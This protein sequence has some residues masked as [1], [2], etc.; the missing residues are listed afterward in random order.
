MQQLLKIISSVLALTVSVCAHGQT[1]PPDFNQQMQKILMTHYNQYKDQEYFSGA[2]L[3]IYIPNDNIRNYYVGR[4]SHSLKSKL[5]SGD[6][7]FQIGSITKSF[8]A[9][10]ILQLEKEGKL[11]LGDTLKTWLPQYNKWSAISMTQLLNMTS[12][13]PNYTESSLLNSQVYYNTSRI[14]RNQELIDFAYPPATFSPPLRSGYFY[15]NTNYILASLIV[16]KATHNT[17]SRELVS[18]TIGMANLN[19][20]FYILNN[21]NSKIQARLAYGYNFNP[22]EFPAMVGKDSYA[23]NLSW[24]AAAGGIISNSE[25]I[26][27][28]VKA[29]FVDNK[30]LDQKQKRKLMA[31]VS[32]VNGQ[33]IDQTTAANPHGFGL[34]LA[35]NLESGV[36]RYWFYEGRTIGFRAIY[37]YKPCNGVIISAIFNSATDHYNDHSGRLLQRTYQ[38]LLARY[39]QLSC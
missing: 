10:I 19:N 5:I 24:A 16:E 7:L 9:A 35:Q 23:G 31:L 37:M 2:E 25:D 21:P 32:A 12:G 4:V 18:R 8:T 34:G 14:W 26:I 13:I 22:Y 28:W 29:L 36:G 1:P 27:K 17:F 30:I 3:S 39:P 15:S 20:T 33:P 6:T 11:R 38:S